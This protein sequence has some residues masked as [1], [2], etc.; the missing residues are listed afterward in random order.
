M[1]M[2]QDKAKTAEL[3][4]IASEK[5]GVPQETLKQEIQSGKFDKALA[6]MKPQDAAN[7]RKILGNPKLLG[8]MMNSQQA[9]ALYEKLSR[10]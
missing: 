3:L 5:L 4:R 9:K 1:Q 6:A 10:F 2:P 7:F 8:Q